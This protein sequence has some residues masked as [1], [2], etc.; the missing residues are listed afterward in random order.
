MATYTRQSQIPELPLVSPDFSFWEKQMQKKAYTYD[1][2]F[3]KV[4]SVYNSVFNSPMLRNGNIEQRDNFLKSISNNL[5]QL[6]SADL[7]LPQNLT[8][9]NN[10]FEPVLQNDNIVHDI[11]YTKSLQ[12]QMQT[13]DSYA[14]SFDPNIKKLYWEGGKQYLNYK[15]EE[16]KKAD[17]AVA[18]GMSAP[19]YIA[20]VDPL[21]LS[22]K[23]FK[24]A[25]ISVQKDVVGKDGYQYTM[26]N[27]DLVVPI[28]KNF[29]THLLSND[30]AYLQYLNANTYV[31][32]KNWI[33]SNLSKFNNDENAASAAWSTKILQEQAASNKLLNDTNIKDDEKSLGEL[34]T[35]LANYDE[36]IKTKG[37]VEGSEDY[38]NYKTVKTQI[39]ALEKGIDAA[40]K[41]TFDG[42]KSLTD[43]KDISMKA[44]AVF[45]NYMFS[46]NVQDI[47]KYLA[48]K[49]AQISIKGKDEYAYETWKNNMDFETHKAKKDYDAIKDLE[50]EQWKY[51]HGA[52]GYGGGTGGSSTGNAVE[53][54]LRGEPQVPVSSLSNVIMNAS[55]TSNRPAGQTVEG[56]NIVT[57][58]DQSVKTTATESNKNIPGGTIKEEESIIYNRNVKYKKEK[59][60]NDY[61]S[62]NVNFIQTA[63]RIAN[64]MPQD[65]AGRNI[66][67]A[68]LPQALSDPKVNA[69]LNDEAKQ[70]L[71]QPQ[72][73][74]N[75]ELVR[76]SRQND[77][78]LALWAASDKMMNADMLIAANAL[79]TGKKKDDKNDYT[80]VLDKNGRI[81]SESEFLKKYEDKLVKPTAVDYTGR[82]YNIDNTSGKVTIADK[83]DKYKNLYKELK[84]LVLDKYNNQPGTRDLS[85]VITG[86]TKSMG[87]KGGGIQPVVMQFN[88]DVQKPSDDLVTLATVLGIVRKSSNSFVRVG[89]P[90]AE[91]PKAN[92]EQAQ[93]LLDELTSNMTTAYGKADGDRPVGSVT[94]SAIVGGTDKYHYYNIKLDAQYIKKLIG[95]KDNPGI[96]YGKDEQ[97]NGLKTK[98]LSLYV[99]ANEDVSLIGQRSMKGASEYEAIMNLSPDGKYMY[100]SP[101]GS[102]FEMYK[103]ANGGLIITGSYKAYDQNTGKVIDIPYNPNREI[104]N[105]GNVPLDDYIDSTI[106]PKFDQ[107][108]EYN[109]SISQ[110]PDANTKLIKDPSLIK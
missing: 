43:P 92:D 74:N 73:K 22:E 62:A 77:R 52:T 83:P 101:D 75:L 12:N 61:G 97:T 82:F 78:A 110:K 39:E 60:V 57:P 85:S 53:R 30:P 13:A 29:V 20:K 80:S 41:L 66:T 55:A 105:I 108:L 99:P 19:K 71:N 67:Y 84:D 103:S 70:I 27:G 95:T 46:Q 8:E 86:S 10:L 48:S 49:N 16:Y 87:P 88:F 5:Q 51:E 54:A 32:R 11:A 104:V 36:L 50:L 79:N 100:K 68:N 6:S 65:V 58:K 93:L 2:N 25:G 23:M 40:K 44:D 7:S 17:D 38:N 76:A 107:L 4:Q 24:D 15:A 81:L 45:T 91:I 26:K 109:N 89:T 9:A 21:E 34:K 3:A 56:I 94:F 63:F 64:R 69:K 28:A 14:N 31:Q 90:G 72:F 37:I 98:G 35:T 106:F 96:L 42:Y 33:N 59:I 47:S 18:L 102:Y 1:Q